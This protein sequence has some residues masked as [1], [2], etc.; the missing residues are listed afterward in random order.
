MVGPG[1][2]SGISDLLARGRPQDCALRDECSQGGL[3]CLW[4]HTHPVPDSHGLPTDRPPDHKAGQRLLART[5][6]PEVRRSLHVTLVSHGRELC[7]PAMPRCEPCP[8]QRFCWYARSKTR[9]KAEA[10]SEK[11]LRV[12]DLFSGAGGMSTGFEMAGSAG[13]RHRGIGGRARYLL[14][15]LPRNDGSQ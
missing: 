8:L 10:A 15:E 13:R 3:F 6:S 12:V 4:T 5:F 11:S 9:S 14:L 1:G 2:F 7:L